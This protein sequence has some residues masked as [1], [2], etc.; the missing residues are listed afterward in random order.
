LPCSPTRPNPSVIHTLELA[1]SLTDQGH[2]VSIY[3][4]DK[5]GQ[6]FDQ[7]LRSTIHLVPT[8]PAPTTIDAL[9]QQRIQAFVDDLST[10]PSQHD[11]YHAQDCIG[12]NALLHLRQTDRI[13][14]FVRTIHHVEAYQSP[15]LQ[16]C[17]GKSIR[18][19]DLR[20]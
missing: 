9:I 15:Y 14:H 4:L 2:T 18:Q 7:S 10:H 5:D 20:L 8:Q 11:I 13:P 1:E 17:Q 16:Q 3:A 19:P 12:A 6:G